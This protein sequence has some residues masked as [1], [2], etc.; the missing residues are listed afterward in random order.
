MYYLFSKNNRLEAVY[1]CDEGDSIENPILQTG[2]YPMG[3]LFSIAIRVLP[4]RIKN[5][6][7]PIL[8]IEKLSEEFKNLSTQVSSFANAT[9]TD[10][11][12]YKVLEL[13]LIDRKHISS[14]KEYSRL[15]ELLQ[16]YMN[17]IVLCQNEKHLCTI[18]TL[19]LFTNQNDIKLPQ[20]YNYITN[21]ISK[22]GNL[23]TDEVYDL[24]S[25]TA[26]PSQNF[27]PPLK[28]KGLKQLFELPSP[29]IEIK[30]T[31]WE[32]L[33]TPMYVFGIHDII[34]FILA[35]L[36][37]IFEENYYIRKC[38][39][40]NTVFAVKEKNTKYCPQQTPDS[41]VHSCYENMKDKRRRE[42]EREK[43]PSESNKRYKCIYNML[44]E[45]TNRDCARDELEI[46]RQE[47][48]DF[49]AQ[50]EEI[51]K[52]RILSD[53]EYIEWMDKYWE[54]TK[55]KAKMRKKKYK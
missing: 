19:T 55:T 41:D 10:P 47:L 27:A 4:F 11:F 2:V 12:V 42:K 8:S 33:T 46:R 25:D 49:T 1:V 24:L 28:N 30:S 48:I 53:E 18:E 13:L 14:D 3:T 20:Y 16:R 37:C 7:D 54:D 50:A 39:Y 21:K 17:F 44:Y 15:I 26:T 32:P 45:R 31:P 43:E 34:D 6:H 23:S 9:C 36:Q 35:S 38:P 5:N 40:C 51:R 29:L 22:Q 52:Q